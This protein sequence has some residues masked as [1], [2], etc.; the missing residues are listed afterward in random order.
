MRIAFVLRGISSYNSNNKIVNYKKSLQN[1]KDYIIEPLLEKGHHIDFFCLTYDTNFVNDLIEDYKPVQ[2]FKMNLN[3][4]HIGG[5]FRRQLDF[6]KKSIELIKNFEY[7]S[8]FTYDL[9]INTRFDLIFK[10]NFFEQNL[11]FSKFNIPF[12]H[13]SGNCEDC[14]FVFPRILLDT[15]EDAVND[16][17]C[18][19]KITHEMNHT[20]L[21]KFIHYCYKLYED[22]YIPYQYYDIIRLNKF[23]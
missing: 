18:K 9:I 20:C 23:D 11:N 3:E 21:N 8:S 19:N 10:T 22:P 17:L 13:L 5:S 14:Y 7:I 12:E 2:I 6:H 1:Y 4:F 16:L 15:F